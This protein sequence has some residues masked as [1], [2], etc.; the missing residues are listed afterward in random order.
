[1]LRR[2]RRWLDERRRARN[3]IATMVRLDIARELAPRFLSEKHPY[4]DDPQLQ[5]LIDERLLDRSAFLQKPPTLLAFYRR[6]L[7]AMD[8]PPAAILEIG[9]K[10]GGSTALW[11]ALFPSATVVGLDIKLRSWLADGPSS[12]GVVYVEGDQTDVPRLR[13]LAREYGPFDLVIDD[14]SHVPR[15]QE[16][17]LRAL[18]PHVRTG[19]VYVVED[20]QTGVKPAAEGR[21]VD[22]GEDVWADFVAGV[23]ALLRGDVARDPGTSGARLATDLVR[24][25]DDLVVAKNVLGIRVRDRAPRGG[26]Q[27]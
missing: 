21:A 10:G 11:K 8:R 16:T 4:R 26:D 6:L 5:A 24:R 25:I 9:V 1:M 22:Y 2:L 23:F 20:I 12:D 14:G 27:R 7:W 18:L 13:A 19:G 3:A 15:H 17:S